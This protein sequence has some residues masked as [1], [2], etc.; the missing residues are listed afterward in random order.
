MTQQPPTVVQL[1]PPGRG[2][3]AT[4]LV[5][6]RGAAE[7]VRRT[8][9][10][11]N[12]RA[13]DDQTQQRLTLARCPADGGEQL[14]VRCRC[15]E[16]VELHCHGG[17]AAA[18]RIVA[19]LRKNGCRKTLWQQW[20]NAH[21]DD[22]ITAAAGVA[23]ADARTRRT[24]AVLLDQYNGALRRAMDEIETS[25]A[26]GN[27]KAAATLVDE[28][29]DRWELGQHLTQ[30]W[31][32]VLA[33]PPNAGK[34]SLINALLGYQRAIVHREPG[35]T[36]D[37]VTAIAI[38]DGWPVELCDTAGLRDTE[39]DTESAGV[40]LAERKLAEADLTLLVFDA[41]KPWTPDDAALARSLPE[42]LL[43]H[44]KSDLPP[45]A[46]PRPEGISTSTIDGSGV[47][48]LLRAIVDRLVPNP[49]PPGAAVPMTHEQ[50]KLLR[51]L[52]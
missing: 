36:R 46:E 51:E 20:L 19:A 16:S 44:N 26:D 17:L 23:L 48:S 39:N 41:S 6:G 40:E 43:I 42:S 50:V 32:V 8:V 13:F 35:T 7:V 33:G 47:E 5:E 14:V 15:D 21:L 12:P 3:V 1:T 49:P 2:A 27:S 28:L 10:L 30:P 38:M 4:L 25:A 52:R 37:V 34:S 18:E 11:A 45:T 24:A 31:R 22:P 29:L 9:K